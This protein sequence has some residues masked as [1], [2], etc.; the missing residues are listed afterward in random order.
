MVP[1]PR[2]L[3]APLDDILPPPLLLLRALAG[4]DSESLSSISRTQHLTTSVAG[5]EHERLMLSCS[6]PA[7]SGPTSAS[8]RRARS[9]GSV[10]RRVVSNGEA[11]CEKGMAARAA[12]TGVAATEVE[13]RRLAG[14]PL[15]G[16]TLPRRLGADASIDCLRCAGVVAPAAAAMA[17]AAALSGSAG[18]CA[19]SEGLRIAIADGSLRSNDALR[20]G[21]AGASL[22]DWS[23]IAGGTAIAA[24]VAGETDLRR[25]AAS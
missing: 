20:C 15:G 17:A 25:P 18:S 12:A 21:A 19:K 13:P 16:R 10:P 6:M 3:P 23:P 7:R 5:V 4:G 9:R 1:V 14:V 11:S 8:T 24:A 2:G 22:C